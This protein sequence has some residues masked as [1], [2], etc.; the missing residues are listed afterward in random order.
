MRVEIIPCLNDNYAYLLEVKEHSDNPS[1]KHILID[2]PD[3]SPI[4][5][6]LEENSLGLDFILSTHHHGDHV[7]ANL[8]LKEKYKCKIYGAEDDADRIPGIDYYLK[9][10]E[11]FKIADTNIESM[12]APGH[13]NNHTVY[14]FTESQFLFSGDTLFSMG[15]GRLFEGTYIEMYKT[16]QKIKTLPDSSLL[17]CGHEYSQKN[18]QFALSVDINNEALEHRYQ[19]V[20]ELLSKGQPTVPTTLALEKQ[21]N[22]FLRAS[23]V[24]EFKKLRQLRDSF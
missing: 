7:G 9:P 18:A 12:I 20:L 11:V 8:E 10:E 14:F 2:A 16:L 21:I 17:Y 3:F 23:S 24:D 4:N 13:T 19:E 6:Y 15:C 1:T 5:N 22:P